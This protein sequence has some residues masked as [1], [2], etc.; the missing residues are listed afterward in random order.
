MQLS[1]VSIG[2]TAAILWGGF[3]LFAGLI[4]LAAPPYASEY[5]QVMSS[6]HPGLPLPASLGGVLAAA[7]A[8]LSD[9]MV[10]GLLFSWIYNG[11]A[12]L[13][14]AEGKLKGAPLSRGI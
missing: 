13:V 7:V 5:L 8:G 2:I 11:L 4:N 12:G 3:T 1:V 10:A 14:T 6:L 9:G